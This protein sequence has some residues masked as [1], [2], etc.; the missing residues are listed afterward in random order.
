MSFNLTIFFR[1]EDSGKTWE[2]INGPP[3]D[4]NI[5][6]IVNIQDTLFARTNYALYRFSDENWQRIEFPVSVGYIHSIAT[7]EE[8]L[9]V[10]AEVGDDVLDSGKVSQGLE[11]GWW[12]FRSTDLG[13][14]W[15]DITPTNAWRVKRASS[16]S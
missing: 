7:A 12:I 8:K 11:R 2:I 9:Y 10:T 15:D 1:S 13:D 3:I 5:Q 6:S 16:P 14:S 4:R